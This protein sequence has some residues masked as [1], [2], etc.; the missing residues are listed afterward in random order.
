MTEWQ[1][2]RLELWCGRTLAGEEKAGE[3]GKAEELARSYLRVC[4][5]YEART[6]KAVDA[7]SQASDRVMVHVGSLAEAA[8]V[9]C[10]V[11]NE[12]HG[13]TM[14]R[15]KAGSLLQH[16]G[17]DH[18]E[19]LQEMLREGVKASLLR[20]RTRQRWSMSM[21]VT[22][23]SG[24]TLGGAVVVLAGGRWSGRDREGGSSH[25]VSSR[26]NPEDAP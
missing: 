24:S 12:E 21:K 6:L 14:E 3:A 8:R 10:T 13:D 22:T 26:P 23:N 25:G 15:L 4:R 2:V 16:L 20:S 17:E 18:G 19:Y 9:N 11:W 5:R 7:A 1:G